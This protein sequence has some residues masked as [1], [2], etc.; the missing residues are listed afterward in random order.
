MSRFR[1]TLSQYT[2]KKNV[3]LFGDLTFQLEEKRIVHISIVVHC[4]T[5]SIGISSL[6]HQNFFTGLLPFEEY[7]EDWLDTDPV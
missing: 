4:L 3:E 6:V 1:L 5:E 7:S 2:V